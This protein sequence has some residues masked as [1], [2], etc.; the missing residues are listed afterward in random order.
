VSAVQIALIAVG[1]VIA[2]AAAARSTWSPCGLSMLSTITPIGERGRGNRYRPTAAWFV[3]GALLGGATTG[4]LMAGLAA[5]VAAVHLPGDAAG[6]VGAGVLAIAG[7]SDL[8]VAGLHLP[9]HRRQVNERWLDQF[10]PWVYGMGFG[11]QIGTGLST[12]VMTAAVYALV[13]V[14]ALTGSTVAAL[15]LG[16]LFGLVRGLCVLLGRGITS[17]ESLRAFHRRFEMI[18][19]RV[20]VGVIALE[21]AM[22]AFL[23]GV[24]WP[25][26]VLLVSAMALAAVASSVRRAPASTVQRTRALPATEPAAPIDRHG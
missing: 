16:C 5:I 19:P 9:Y 26:G 6:A 18:G 3:A 21:A 14:G 22:A 17:P 7:G 20:R 24:V 13:V 10:R 4:G 23:A 25:P 1:V 2:V 8:G 11:W 12:Y 15:A